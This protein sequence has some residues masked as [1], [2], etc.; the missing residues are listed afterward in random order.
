MQV[1]SKVIE[2]EGRD[3]KRCLPSTEKK[4]AIDVDH[5]A[6]YFKASRPRK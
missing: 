1:T 2:K 3:E 6:V 4:A 5:P